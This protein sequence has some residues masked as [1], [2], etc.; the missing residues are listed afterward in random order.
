MKL[1]PIIFT[2]AALLMLTGCV[3]K[4]ARAKE[5]KANPTFM[6][7]CFRKEIV[8]SDYH[9][10]EM[11][12]PAAASYLQNKLKGVPGYVS[13][14]YN[15]AAQVMTV[16]YKSSSVRKMNFEEAIALAGFTVNHRPA[17]PKA[18]VPEGIK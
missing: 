1:R 4:E 9:I 8:S 2:A 7:W 3:D 12:K 18:V 6:F 17:S 10:P 16:S 5:K 13:S 11:K 15:L 14:E